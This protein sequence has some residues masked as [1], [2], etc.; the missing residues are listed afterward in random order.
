MTTYVDIKYHLVT[1]IISMVQGE[2]SEGRC[3]EYKNE[4]EGPSLLG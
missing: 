1:P 3:F 2:R 4:G